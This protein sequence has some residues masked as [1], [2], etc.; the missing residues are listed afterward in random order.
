VH[1]SYHVHSIWSDGKHSLAELQQAAAEAGLAEWGVS[2]HVVMRPGGEPVRWSMDPAR[3]PLYVAAVHAAQA[4]APPERPLRLGLELDFFPGSEKRLADLI[5]GYRF[6][7]VM[8]AV[9]YVDGFLVDDDLAH[10]K[11]LSPAEVDDVWRG[12]FVRIGGLA[13]SGLFSFIAHLDLPKAF[14]YRPTADLTDHVGAALDA[15]ARAGLAVEVNTSGW[16]RPCGEAYPSLDLLRACR[17]R[18]IP[19]MVNAD[20]HSRED[21][22]R[23]LDRGML[24]LRE[25]GYDEVVRLE[26]RHLRPVPMPLAQGITGTE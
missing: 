13:R 25:A 5:S 9:H 22:T 10:W 23:D 11:T 4:E 19:A 1:T 3:L 26:D 7:Y 2:D 21:L 18:G 8:G 24:L 17:A 14:D 12:Y 6:D 15:V 20:A 16:R